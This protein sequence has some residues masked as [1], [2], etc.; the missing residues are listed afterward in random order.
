MDNYNEK[1]SF[2]DYTVVGS[3]TGGDAQTVA[4]DFFGRVFA[5]M[6]AGLAISALL[7]YIFTS[8]PAFTE[9]LFDVSAN[10]RS[11]PSALG[12]LVIFAPIGFVMLMSFGFSKLSQGALAVVFLLYSAV[13]GISF[14]FILSQ[15]AGSS[16]LGC[17]LGSAAMFGVMA[18]MGYTT[19]K[20]LTSMGRL[21]FMGLI[22]ILIASLIN[23][24][25]GSAMMDYV[26]SIL[27][28][29]IFTG[30]TAYDTQKLK[31]IGMGLQYGDVSKADTNKMAILGALNLY[32]D[33][34]NL[35]LFVLRLF[36][37]RK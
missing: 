35:F 15:Y 20:D 21:L 5:F 10:G 12:Y 9:Y 22:G 11:A 36:G 27:G 37:R 17:F 34:V 4:K 31:H 2:T 18:V 26:V 29:I 23:I 3:T 19:D 25:I 14:A 13:N 6:F 8:N 24:L 33:F 7:A 1:Q 30:L 16:I 32:L 28:V